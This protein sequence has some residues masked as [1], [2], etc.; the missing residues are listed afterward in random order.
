MPSVSQE[1]GFTD[2]TRGRN[3][4]KAS[5]SPPFPSQPKPP[6]GTPVRPKLN[7]KNTVPVILSGIN[8]EFRN[9]KKLMGEIRQFHPSFKISQIKE[10]SKGHFLIIGDSVQDITILQ[11]ESKMKAS[12]SKNVKVS[13]PKD[14]QV[15]K[16]QTKRL[17]IKGVLTDITDKEFQEFLDL[18]KINYAKAECLQSNKDG[19]VLPI[20]QLEI[21]DPTKAVA[22]FFLKI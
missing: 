19:R 11:S 21:N 5:G 15:N 4:C 10:L 22:L 13:L 14:F 7:I 3:K 12:L 6:L 9:W 1:D 17:A 2:V 20:F 16:G 8:V 18:N